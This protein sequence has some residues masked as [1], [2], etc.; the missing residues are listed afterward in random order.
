MEDLG[1]WKLT[2]SP[3]LTTDSLD[4]PPG[5]GR[6]FAA[7]SE[8]LSSQLGN[9]IEIEGLKDPGTTGNFEVTAGGQLIH[10]KRT[11]QGGLAETPKERKFIV[12]AIQ[13]LIEDAE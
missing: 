9:A 5:Y 7:L 11:G 13:A 12:S 4:S 10:S 1:H 3:L 2:T 6:H 8:F